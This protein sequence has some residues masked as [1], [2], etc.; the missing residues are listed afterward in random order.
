MKPSPCQTQRPPAEL[1]SAYLRKALLYRKS[2]KFSAQEREAAAETVSGAGVVSAA[3]TVP[4]AGVVSA[5]ETVPGAEA[6][7]EA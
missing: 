7:T 3:E 5:A 2:R 6:Q 4:G 1:V